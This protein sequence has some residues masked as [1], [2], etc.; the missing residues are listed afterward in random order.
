MV[1]PRTTRFLIACML[2]AGVLACSS[3]HDDSGGGAGGGGN[4]ASAEWW[5]TCNAGGSLVVHDPPEAACAKACENLGGVKSLE[6]RI[7]AI[8]TPEC[9]AFCAKAD[10]LGCPGD[11]CASHED[12]WCEG[13]PSECIEALA[14]KLACSVEQGDWSCD[15]DSWQMTS[16]CPSFSELCGAGGGAGN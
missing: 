15:E 8:G 4:G 3:T 13:S 11:S 16:G 5:C 2:C 14:A 9:D 7:S 12:F 6:P 1:A 10:A